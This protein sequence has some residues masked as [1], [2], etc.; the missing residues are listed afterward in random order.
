MNLTNLLRVAFYAMVRT[1]S[2]G[3]KSSKKQRGNARRMVRRR[4]RQESINE[5]ATEKHAFHSRLTPWFSG[6]RFDLDQ[7][8]YFSEFCPGYGAR[9]VSYG[10]LGV[11][12]GMKAG[13]NG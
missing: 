3:P 2:T 13:N 8:R 4:Q 10:A 6:H 5:Q 1:D 12:H 7:C 11:N 9:C